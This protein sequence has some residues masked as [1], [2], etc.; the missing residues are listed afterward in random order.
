MN[1]KPTLLLL[2]LI[3]LFSCK[4]HE[5]NAIT[6][7]TAIAVELMDDTAHKYLKTLKPTEE[8]YALIFNE[9]ESTN[10][11]TKY[12]ENKWSGIDNVPDDGMKPL[13]DDAELKIL[14]ATKAELLSG[15]TNGLPTGYTK[16]A[17]HLKEG[18]TIYGIQYLNTDGT[19]QKL[20]TAF[21]K[22]NDRWIIIPQAFK[23]FK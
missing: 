17:T 20:R 19:E 15:N 22:V 18:S 9:G 14:S 6:E 12:S 5:E 7:L 10:I 3:A 11:I 1:T 13:T 21:F 4:A 2:I 23:A 8:D 16:L